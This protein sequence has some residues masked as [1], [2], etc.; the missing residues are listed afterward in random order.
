[1]FPF[2]DVAGGFA[3]VEVVD[4]GE[5]VHAFVD[6]DAVDLAGEEPDVA[7]GDEPADVVPLNKFSTFSK[8]QR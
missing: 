3:V 5:A 6:E 4:A 1:M 8:P 7:F 2:L